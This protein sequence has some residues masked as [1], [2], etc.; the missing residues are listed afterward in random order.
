MSEPV[1]RLFVES[2]SSIP[3]ASSPNH[4]LKNIIHMI[5][6]SSEDGPLPGYLVDPESI[7]FPKVCVIHFDQIF[8]LR[9]MV[10]SAGFKLLVVPVEAELQFDKGIIYEAF[11]EAVSSALGVNMVIAG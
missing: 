1:I 8:Q 9:D 7:I 2:H 5:G 11:V 4:E 6:G 3:F 10:E